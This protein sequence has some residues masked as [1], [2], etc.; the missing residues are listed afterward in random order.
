MYILYTYMESNEEFAK[1]VSFS[2]NGRAPTH[3]TDRLFHCYMLDESIYHFQGVGSILSFL[4]LFLM[5]NHVGQY[6]KP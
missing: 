2:R 1:V 3:H 4:I 6:C 5:E